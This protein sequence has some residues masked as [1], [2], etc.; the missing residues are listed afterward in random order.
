MQSRFSQIEGVSYGMFH[1]CTL[2]SKRESDIYSPTRTAAI[3]PAPPETK[4]LTDSTV[5]ERWTSSAAG[6]S[7]YPRIQRVRILQQHASPRYNSP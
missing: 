6:A 4:D 7:L 2:S 5:D 3:P 1:P